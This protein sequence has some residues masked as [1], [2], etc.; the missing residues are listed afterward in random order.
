[1][2]F[3]NLNTP[4]KKYAYKSNY[5][6]DFETEKTL[7]DFETIKLPILLKE[8]K[9]STE[10][11]LFRVQYSQVLNIY[12]EN[13]LYAFLLV[14]NVD[15]KTKTLLN[16]LITIDKDSIDVIKRFIWR[17]NRNNAIFTIF[18][19][20]SNDKKVNSIN[21]LDKIMDGNKNTYYFLNHDK[22]DF[23]KENLKMANYEKVRDLS[24][25]TNIQNQY[26]KLPPSTEEQFISKREY[27]YLLKTRKILHR[28]YNTRN[29]NENTFIELD[30]NTILI[31][32]STKNNLV[33]PKYRVLIDKDDYILV[34]DINWFV[35]EIPEAD[36]HP[37][38][39]R[40]P[41]ANIKGVVL[42]MYEFLIKEEYLPENDKFDLIIDHNNRNRLDNRRSN[43]KL[44][45]FVENNR[46]QCTRVNNSSGVT[47]VRFN[48][49]KNAWFAKRDIY[50]EGRFGKPKARALR[51]N[52][53]EEAVIIRK[54]LEKIPDNAFLSDSPTVDLIKKYGDPNFTPKEKNSHSTRRYF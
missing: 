39:L 54:Y 21:I 52:S 28:N 33:Y 23:R 45:N 5:F 44:S 1:M 40:T 53:F 48:P 10:N 34:K 22:D 24:I 38:H 18:M 6:T 51:T 25:N 19:D 46:N 27:N 17:T 37:A 43:L 42:T 16:R 9:L 4:K 41:K 2:N 11:E 20:P 7:K 29:Q 32:I 3:E 13:D 8:M 47:G 50:P 49:Q 31:A 15:F 26:K 36:R 30:Q 12:Y 14:A 35:S